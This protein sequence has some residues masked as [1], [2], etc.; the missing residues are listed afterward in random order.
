MCFI[1]DFIPIYGKCLEMSATFWTVSYGSQT[2]HWASLNC[3]PNLDFYREVQ[4]AKLLIA[5]T[6]GLAFHFFLEVKG[7]ADCWW[8]DRNEG[9]TVSAHGQKWWGR[10]AYG[11]STGVS[12][13]CL[14]SNR[15]DLNSL[16][17]YSTVSC[18]ETVT[19]NPSH[20]VLVF[21]PR[22]PLPEVLLGHHCPTHWSQ[23]KSDL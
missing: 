9:M 14:E 17:I 1:N 4:T 16:Q 22:S 8:L 18:R 20:S 13:W 2:I 19:V 23:D 15:T 11:V 12:R 21:L 6:L 7:T 10:G 3:Y 5:V